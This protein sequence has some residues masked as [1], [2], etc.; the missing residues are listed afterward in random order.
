MA[1]DE[2]IYTTALSQTVIDK[3]IA[4][5]PV[6]EYQRYDYYHKSLH[7]CFVIGWFLFQYFLSTP[8]F[9]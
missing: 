4:L 8:S 3:S 9:E 1:T 7:I 6:D 2:E 5:Q